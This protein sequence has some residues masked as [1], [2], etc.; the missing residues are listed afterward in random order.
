MYALTGIA[1]G[2]ERFEP[3]FMITHFSGTC[4]VKTPDSDSFVAAV[5]S[6]AYPYGTTVKTGAKSSANI[7]FS[8]NNTCRLL[9]NSK[10]ELTENSKNPKLKH[11]LLDFGKVEVS[12]DEELKETGNQIRIKTPTAICDAPGTRFT[13]AVQIEQDLKIAAFLVKN[14]VI[15]VWGDHFTVPELVKDGSVSIAAS[16]DM[17]F[18]RLRNLKGKYKVQIRDEKG[19]P[20]LVDT[21]PG[22]TLKI[23]QRWSPDGKSLMVTTVLVSPD[24]ELQES[25]THTVDADAL[26][27]IPKEFLPERPEVDDEDEKETETTTT[28]VPEKVTVVT[29][30]TSTSTTTTTTT[31]PSVTPVGRF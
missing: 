11:L 18:I 28:T 30:T 9:A 12:L 2:A 20:R 6:K 22:T 14:G 1:M 15:K 19:E 5:Q 10:M 21:E 23:H 8:K 17:S 29:T 13:V 24:G 16:R 31:V 3:L 27:D 4:E 25:L 26:A 7:E